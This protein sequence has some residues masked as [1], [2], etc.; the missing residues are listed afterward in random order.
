MKLQGQGVVE[1][2]EGTTR[3]V[4]AQALK[5]SLSAALAVQFK[6]VHVRSPSN[7]DAIDVLEALIVSRRNPGQRV[8][9][10][11][12]EVG[13]PRNVG[14]ADALEL[15]KAG[16][17]VG[18]QELADSGHE[19]A[20]LGRGGEVAD[21]DRNGLGVGKSSIRRG[22]SCRTIQRRPRRSIMSVSLA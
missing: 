8:R 14:H 20:D 21:D 17:I 6:L 13:I 19:P 11:L 16:W 22:S 10:G 4:C 5:R 3:I 12:E 15:P 9:A 2:A 18:P 7:D 1:T